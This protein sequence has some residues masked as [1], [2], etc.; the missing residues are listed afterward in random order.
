MGGGRAVLHVHDATDGAF[1][2]AHVEEVATRTDLERDRARRLCEQVSLRRAGQPVR[3]REHHP[4]AVARVVGEEERAGVTRRIRTAFVEGEPRDRRPARLAPGDEIVGVA[5]RGVGTGRRAGACVQ[6]LTHRKVGGVVAAGWR[7]GALV[8]RPAEVLDN[9]VVDVG[10]PIHLF[11]DRPADVTEPQFLRAGPE[12]EPERVAQ[13]VGDDPARVE[14]A[15][16]S[17]RIAGHRGA[18]VGVETKHRTTEADRVS[19]W[20]GDPAPLSAPPSQRWVAAGI[21]GLPTDRSRRSDAAHLH[22]RSCRARRR[23]RTSSAPIEW[24]GNCWHQS[25]ISTCSD[26]AV[27]PLAVRRDSR[28]LTTQPSATAPGGSGS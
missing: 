13:T 12:R 14:V 25:L 8:A 11:V 20:C 28:P 23:G 27:F 9:A 6:R 26:V 16:P 7:T 2:V 22:R 4:D 21:S 18:G 15:A 19:G 3:S 24:L 1:P 10:D 5:V 17:E